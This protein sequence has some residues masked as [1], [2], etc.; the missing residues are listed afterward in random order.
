VRLTRAHVGVVLAVGAAAGLAL[1]AAL[2]AGGD[3]APKEDPDYVSR[4][5]Q[6]LTAINRAQIEAG[7]EPA[8]LSD[9]LPADCDKEA[10][11]E[12]NREQAERFA[13][14]IPPTELR[15]AHRKA[16]DAMEKISGV[17]ATPTEGIEDALR[18]DP[19]IVVGVFDYRDWQEAF[20]RHFEVRLFRLDGASMAPT[21]NNGDT[22]ALDVFRGE[23]LQR[24]VL[25]AFDFHLAPDRQ[26]MKRV[27]GLPGET[28]EVRDGTVFVDGSPLEEDYLNNQPNY[29]YGP[30]TVPEGHYFVLG[31][32]RRNS[33]DSHAWGSQ[34]APEQNCDFVPEENIIGVLAA[35][36]MPDKP[37]GD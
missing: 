11:A 31:D 36:A 27:V 24:R 30:R 12:A 33:S 19:E 18:E 6:I 13:D 7:C 14:L 23:P 17:V 22:V 35:E 1:V 20:E 26:F 15:T 25:I 21:F 3:G 32:N 8:F 5:A 34:C 37:A 28:I 29:T 4:V 2:L 16:A 10:W 9:D